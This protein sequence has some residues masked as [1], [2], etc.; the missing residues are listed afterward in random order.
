[1]HGTHDGVIPLARATQSRDLLKSMGYNVEWHEY[2]MQHSLCAEEV[3]DIA[4][5]LKKVLL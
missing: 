4:A 5:W 1:V 3:Q 2:Y